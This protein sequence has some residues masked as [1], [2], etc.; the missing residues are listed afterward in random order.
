VSETPDNAA[1]PSR[2]PDD[3]LPQAAPETPPAADVVAQVPDDGDVEVT[4]VKPCR[5]TFP[6]GHTEL[7]KSGVHSLPAAIADNWFIQAHTANPPPAQLLP[8][9]PAFVDNQRKLAAAAAAIKAAEDQQVL[10][11]ADAARDAIK[12]RRGR[13]A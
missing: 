3:L 12:A 5:F 10:V 4:L 11:A 8:G 1:Q 6:D 2:L 9:T 7:L 13:R